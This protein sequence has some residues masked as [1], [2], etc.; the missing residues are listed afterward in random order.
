MRK[1]LSAIYV[2]IAWLTVA[3]L[4][5]TIFM[6]G[7]S[8]FV[9]NSLWETHMTFGWTSELP[10]LLMIVLAVILRIPRKLTPWLV[11]VVVLHF[12]QTTLPT[13]K[14]SLPVV[15]AFHPLN[16]S[17]LTFIAYLQAKKAGELLLKQEARA[18]TASSQAEA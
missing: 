15:A 6:A 17:V 9:S 16:A 12:V 13:L 7:M 8:L 18:Q 5:A 2:G 14:D 1:T 3:A 10:V 4:L 11:A